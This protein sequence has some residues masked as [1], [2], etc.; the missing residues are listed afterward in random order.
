MGIVFQD[1]T[2]DHVSGPIQTAQGD[3]AE[4]SGE[5]AIKGAELI[6]SMVLK[7]SRETLDL[8]REL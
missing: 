4:S 7:G 3:A 2:D 1:D 8:R 6:C 5:G